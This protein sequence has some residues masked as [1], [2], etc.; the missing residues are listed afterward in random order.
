MAKL[1]KP[2]T[3]VE[4]LAPAPRVKPVTQ[5]VETPRKQIVKPF[6]ATPKKQ[7]QPRPLLQPKF[8]VSVTSKPDFNKCPGKFIPSEAK[9]MGLKHKENADLVLGVH[10]N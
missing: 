1:L 4:A 3:T 8:G 9:F 2:K 10:L 7:D 5:L 6:Q